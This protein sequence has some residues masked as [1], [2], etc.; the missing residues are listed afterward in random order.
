MVDV[1]VRHGRGRKPA[2]T[3]APVPG[4][5]DVLQRLGSSQKRLRAG[6]LAEVEAT[7]A[8]KTGQLCKVEEV[9]PVRVSFI[10][11]A[12][13]LLPRPPDG[14]LAVEDVT[15]TGVALRL[16]DGEESS[17]AAG[18]VPEFRVSLTLL[19][20]PYGFPPLVQVDGLSGHIAQR[21]AGQHV[22]AGVVGGVQIHGEILSSLSQ[23]ARVVA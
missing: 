12:L 2:E 3:H 14:G 6:R 5:S 20:E 22:I 4:V 11:T 13:P 15:E 17:D 21:A 8:L 18:R 23:K 16:P 19:G 10:P 9:S 7:H 1:A